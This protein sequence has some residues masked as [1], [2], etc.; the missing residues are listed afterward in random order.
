MDDFESIAFEPGQ[1]IFN[2]GDIA[3]K[4][5]IIKSGSVNLIGGNGQ[6]FAQVS[7][8]QSFGEQAILS[9]GIRSAGAQAH[10]RVECYNISADKANSLLKARAPIFILMVENPA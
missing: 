6:V 3:D 7:T 1:R 2:A 5:Y 10:D 8:G 4:L 9:G